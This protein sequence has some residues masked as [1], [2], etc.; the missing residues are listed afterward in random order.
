MKVTEVIIVE[1]LE[2]LLDLLRHSNLSFTE[3]AIIEKFVQRFQPRKAI[4]VDDFKNF[5]EKEIDIATGEEK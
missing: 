5:I 1:E 4:M 3:Q 2:L